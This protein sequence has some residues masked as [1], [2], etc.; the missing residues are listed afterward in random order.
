[1]DRYEIDRYRSLQRKQHAARVLELRHERKTE[2]ERLVALKKS[3][4]TK[5]DVDQINSE[6]HAA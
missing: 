3:L 6:R 2:Q 1:M 4:Q 5:L